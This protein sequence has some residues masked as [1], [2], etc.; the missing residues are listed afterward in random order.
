MY[1]IDAWIINTIIKAYNILMC[2]SILICIMCSKINNKRYIVNHS[3]LNI[4]LLS[5]LN[6]IN[7]QFRSHEHYFNDTFYYNHKVIILNIIY[8]YKINLY[9]NIINSYASNFDM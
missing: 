9:K 1:F 3:T 5:N 6:L 7:N 2:I 8:Y 4:S